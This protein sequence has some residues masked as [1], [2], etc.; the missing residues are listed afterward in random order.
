MPLTPSELHNFESPA[1]RLRNAGLSSSLFQRLS[2]AP[3]M[4][5]SEPLSATIRP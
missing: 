5:M 1:V 2:M 3:L 4:Y